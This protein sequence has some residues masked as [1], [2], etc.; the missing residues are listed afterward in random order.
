MFTH[1]KITVYGQNSMSLVRVKDKFSPVSEHHAVVVYL[2]CEYE[3]E[4][5]ASYPNGILERSVTGLN[6]AIVL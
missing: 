6:L 1:R 2:V 3:G 5:S 4:W